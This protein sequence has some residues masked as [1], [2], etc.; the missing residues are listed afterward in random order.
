MLGHERYKIPVSEYVTP[1]P[2]TVSP[3]T[4]LQDI[5]ELLKNYEIRHLP[6][7]EDNRP[8]GII[9]TRD[10]KMLEKHNNALSLLARDIMTPSPYTISPDT[11]L[12]R[13]AFDLSNYKIGSALIIDQDNSLTG[14]FTTT[15][16]LN[17]LI[18]VI[19]AEVEEE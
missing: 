10:I 5:I 14:I 16:A 15:D 12:E 9:S 8:I 11:P 6:V 2:V 19:R 4:S 17:A 3:D 1:N 7:I 13:A 18:E